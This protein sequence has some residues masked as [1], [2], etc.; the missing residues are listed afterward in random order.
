MNLELD[1]VAKALYL[2]LAPGRNAD[3]VEL[4]DAVLADVD[5]AGALL[6]IEFVHAEDLE[7]FLREHPELPALPSRL[8]WVI[9]DRDA[10]WEVETGTEEAEAGGGARL[11][12]ALNAALVDEVIADPSLVER[13]PDGAIVIPI[14]AGSAHLSAD[15]ALEL[16]RRIAEQGGVP[17]LQPLGITTPERPEWS[18]TQIR[19]LKIRHFKPTWPE[20]G[21]SSAPR[22]RYYLDSDVMAVNLVPGRDIEAE[23]GL[24]RIVPL[25]HPWY[26]VLVVDQETQSIV[27]HFMPGFQGVFLRRSPEAATWLAHAEFRRTTPTAVRDLLAGFSEPTTSEAIEEGRELAKAV[28][29]G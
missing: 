1:T 28:R 11:N 4:N 5:A 10:S 23:V 13:I 24:D 21:A 9:I 25:L 17:I 3:T 15:D 16:A 27:G 19:N 8:R 26:G 7:G 6:G 12:L 29:A 22:L 2:R 14:R 20:G 18:P